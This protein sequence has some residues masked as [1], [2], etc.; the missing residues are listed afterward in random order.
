MSTFGITMLAVTLMAVLG[1][2]PWA[3][4]QVYVGSGEPGGWFG[5]DPLPET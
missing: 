3:D 5:T 1:V 4:A 2:V